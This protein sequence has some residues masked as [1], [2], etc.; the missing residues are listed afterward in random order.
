MNTVVSNDLP[1]LLDKKVQPVSL[2]AKTLSR[3]LEI[4]FDDGKAFVL[5]FELMRVYSPSAEVRGHGLGQET[6]QVGKRSVSVVGI[7]AVGN[8]AIKPIFTD[9]HESGIFTWE[10]L[11]WLGEHQAILW[12]DYLRRLQAA[13]YADESGRDAMPA[14]KSVGKCGS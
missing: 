14:S 11:Y 6:L 8:Y 13:G 4:A 2:N 7:E 3:I 1:P 9:Q 5:P 12:T 10:Y